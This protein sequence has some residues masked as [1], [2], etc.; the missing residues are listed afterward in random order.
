[1][2]R[3]QIQ[4]KGRRG[5]GS[6]VTRKDERAHLVADL[7]ICERCAIQA[8]LQQCIQQSSRFLLLRVEQLAAPFDDLVGEVVQTLDAHPLLAVA[9]GP[10][11]PEEQRW[12][13]MRSHETSRQNVGD[14]AGKKNELIFGSGQTPI[15]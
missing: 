7:G 6:V 4:A 5:C 3:Q 14:A 2:P 15:D 11:Q 9:T 12:Q 1:M 10:Q 8:C 13:Q